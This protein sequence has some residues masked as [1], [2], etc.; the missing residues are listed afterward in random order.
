[1]NATQVSR[2]HPGDLRVLTLNLNQRYGAWSDRRSVLMDGFRALQPDLLAFQES[3]Q[4]GDYDQV[5]DLLG[6]GFN[7][8]HQKNRD[9]NG[10]GVSIASR[11]PL[12]AV[13]EVDLDRVFDEL[14]HGVWASDHFGVVADFKV[15][16]SIRS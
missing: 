1:M 16:P 6:P 5:V 4:T 14:V 12:G 7:V 10:M 2:P 9:P 3:I 15:A 13:R 11:W 8:A